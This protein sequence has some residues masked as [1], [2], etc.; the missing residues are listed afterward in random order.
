MV[1]HK[2]NCHCALEN[3]LWADQVT[4]KV[5][6]GANPLFLVYGKKAIIPASIYLP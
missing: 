5:S 6:L 1:D 4:Q 2:R 3:A